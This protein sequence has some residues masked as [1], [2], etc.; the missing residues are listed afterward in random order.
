LQ[1]TDLKEKKIYVFPVQ[2]W[3][4]AGHTYHLFEFDAFLPQEDKQ[5]AERKLELAR[6]CMLYEFDQSIK[7]GPKQVNIFD[8]FVCK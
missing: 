7:G 1:L 2:R 5:I 6:K 4:A 8:I 3:I